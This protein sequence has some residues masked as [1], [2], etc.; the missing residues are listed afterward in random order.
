MNRKHIPAFLALFALALAP[1]LAIGDEA[2]PAGNDPKNDPKNDAKK[3]API[4]PI[5]SDE[6]VEQA[7]AEFKEAF[8]AKGLKGDERSAERDF[9]ME[10]LA[11]YQHKKVVDTIAKKMRHADEYVRLAAVVHLGSQRALPAYAGKKIAEMAK[12]FRKD[13]YF[14]ISAFDAMGKLKYLGARE[15]L[16]DGLR[17][18]DFGVKK[19]AIAAIGNIGEYRLLYAM[20]KEVGIDAERVASE[21]EGGGQPEQEGERIEWEGAEAHVDTGTAGDGDQKAAEKAAKEQAAANK[22]AAEQK[23]AMGGGG[24]ASGAS[25]NR[26]RGASGRSKQEL[27]WPIK[28][29]LSKLTGE[30]FNDTKS[31]HTWLRANDGWMKTKVKEVNTAEKTQKDADKQKLKKK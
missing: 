17:H 20:L 21:P 11:A 10:Q 26:G 24:P 9:A 27:V 15:Q 13:L 19:A 1:S 31:I 4:P 7:L 12:K 8:K 25:S 5:A 28:A 30:D 14:L 22:A 18:Q 2:K 16:A 29:T 3:E 23:A 6:E